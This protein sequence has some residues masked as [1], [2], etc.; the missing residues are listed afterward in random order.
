MKSKGL[1]SEIVEEAASSSKAVVAQFEEEVGLHVNTIS[2]DCQCFDIHILNFLYIYI[3]MLYIYICIF[4][5]T[6]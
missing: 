5:C 4:Y 2:S 6:N 1:A 3:Y